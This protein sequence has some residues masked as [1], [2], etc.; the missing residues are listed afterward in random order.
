MLARLG[1]LIA[2]KSHEA[3]FSAL[4]TQLMCVNVIHWMFLAR[5]THHFLGKTSPIT[6]LGIAFCACW[7]VALGAW[8]T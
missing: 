4:L 2:Q 7:L 3:R 8:R 6:I 5:W 1:H